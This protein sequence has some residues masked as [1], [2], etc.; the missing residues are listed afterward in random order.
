MGRASVP[1][2]ASGGAFD[3]VLKG[4]VT[5]LGGGGKLT[6]AS[7]EIGGRGAGAVNAELT[8]FPGSVRVEALAPSVNTSL[9]ISVGLAKPNPFDG[10]ATLADYDIGALLG[11]AGVAAA[12]AGSMRGRISSSVVMKG[13]LRNPQAAN[14]TLDVAPIEATAFDVPIVMSRGLRASMTGGVLRLEDVTTNIG[15]LAVNLGGVFATDRSSGTLRLDV[16]GDVAPLTP[17][18]SRLSKGDAVAAAGRIT[19]HLQTRVSSAGLVTTGTLNTTLTT[20][21]KGD[22]ILSRD[23]RAAVVLTGG[24]AELREAMGS[25]LGGELTATGDAPLSWLNQWLPSGFHLAPPAIDRPAALE[26]TASI[27]LPAVFEIFQRTP[28][29]AVGGSIELS[30]KLTASSPDVAAIEGDLTLERAAVTVK[31]LTYTQSD[32]TRLRLNSGALTIESLDWRGP[33][34]KVVGSGTLG[35][36]LVKGIET[37]VRLD[38]DT[39]LG[40]LGLLLSGRATG[41]LTGTIEV[42]GEA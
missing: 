24:R 32:V 22:R 25:V 17:W 41:R 4:P 14:V 2:A 6:I 39:E 33:G 21:S 42:H 30:A 19:A 38:V 23:V 36:G 16:D 20:L 11:L 1:I 29:E 3:G 9:N 13:D 37:N 8:V 31:D 15:G 26:G 7:V 34:S 28:M 35:L 18:F 40:I 12:D 10:R 27:D 5:K